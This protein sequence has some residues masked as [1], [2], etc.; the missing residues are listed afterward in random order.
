MAALA[1][2]GLSA[3][4]G[5]IVL[6]ADPTGAALGLPLA[7]LE[8]SPFRDYAIP[9]LVLLTALGV[10]PLW[11][12]YGLWLERAWSWTGALLVGLALLGWL[13]VEI[14]VV[15]YQPQ[16]PLQLLYG[17]VGALVVALCLL[18]SVRRRLRRGR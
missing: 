15:G 7:W 3:V 18:P 9:G 16:P 5:G 13:A 12:V 17:L 11:V 10:G 14:A 4:A 1:F 8:G 2:Q 6:L